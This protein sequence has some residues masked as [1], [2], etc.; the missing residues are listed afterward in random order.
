MVFMERREGHPLAAMLLL[1]SMFAFALVFHSVTQPVAEL[2][3]RYDYQLTAMAR[4]AVEQPPSFAVPRETALA[5][6]STAITATP[7][8]IPLA[9][10]LSPSLIEAFAWP[11]TTSF[12]APVSASAPS[13]ARRESGAVTRAFATT[14]SAL[15]NALRKTF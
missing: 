2:P 10:P 11:A 3:A 5:P 8:E 9:A 13:E 12:P 6:T 7:I 1:C 4:P 15:R 14:G